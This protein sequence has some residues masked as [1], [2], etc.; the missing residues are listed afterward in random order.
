MI[1]R[2]NFVRTAIAASLMAIGTAAFAQADNTNSASDPTYYGSWYYWNPFVSSPTVEVYTY[3]DYSTPR[4]YLYGP[5]A[6]YHGPG[7]Y[8]SWAYYDTPTNPS[9]SASASLGTQ[10]GYM[11]PRDVTR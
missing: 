10:P 9:W 6:N 1:K 3:R 11:G 4:W 8:D 2:K 5:R 7:Y